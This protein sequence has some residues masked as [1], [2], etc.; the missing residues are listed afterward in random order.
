M[1]FLQT[2]NEAWDSL[3][4]N[5]MRSILTTLGIV[6]GVAAVI[7]MIAI[8][9]GAQDTILNQ[10]SGIGTNLLFIFEGNEQD[11]TV[12]VS[13]LTMQDAN[14]IGEVLAAPHVDVVAPVI[15]GS[16]IIKFSGESKSTQILGVTPEFQEARNYEL[17]EGEFISEENVNGRASVALI[18]VDVADQLFGQSEN[19]VGETVTI[20]GQPFRIIGV[21]APKGGGQFGSQ[22]D[23]VLVPITTARS[24]LLTR[25]QGKVDL[26]YVKAISADSVPEATTEIQEILR[27]RHR[28]SLGE[29]DFTIY[30]QQDFLSL[31]SSITNIFKIFLSGIAGIS[32]LVG[33]IGI[34]NIMLVSVTERTKEIGLRKAIGAK[35]KDILIQFLTESSLLSMLGGIL[36]I[37]LG[38]IISALV[39]SI[40]T[41]QGVSFQPQ[42]G[43]NAIILATLFSTAVGLFFGIYPANKAANL[44][45][46]EAL[47]HE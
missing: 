8:G 39:G 27:K 38:W 23:V 19:L 36:G 4:S 24:R 32:L 10:I 26:I 1:N 6:I 42:V 29:D 43:L 20:E 16:G 47:R 25:D 28:T 34:M 31:A 37:I 7:A 2:V 9:T 15:Q 13:P 44:E 46:V 30:S 33:G 45:P 18:G 35:K 12:N 21:L 11:E 40:A 14:A 3:Y 5:K 41:A 17:T 22:D